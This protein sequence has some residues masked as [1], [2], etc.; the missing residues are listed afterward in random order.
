MF[1][2]KGDI[3][4]ATTYKEKILNRIENDS[5]SVF[6]ADDFFDITGYETV[7]STLNRLADKG[8]IKRIIKGIY[9]KPKYFEILDDYESPSIP[10]VAKAIARKYNWNIAPSGNTALNLLGL[11]T[12]VPSKWSYISN[13]RYVTVQVGN[14]T[15]E[16]KHR[17]GAEISNM[18]EDTAM[19][20]QAIKTIG[21][22]KVTENK[23]DHL[24]TRLS[25]DQKENLLNESKSASKWI[26]AIIRKICEE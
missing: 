3:K 22:G 7:R 12:Q 5:G 25:K 23:I 8:T 17:N 26:Y 6:I 13:G 1:G 2:A 16:F 10:K 24:K 21:K 9:Y 20:I 4:M 18:T 15:I 14:T 19:V 11:D